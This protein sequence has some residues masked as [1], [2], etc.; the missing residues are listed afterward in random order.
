MVTVTVAVIIFAAGNFVFNIE[1]T[2]CM[3]APESTASSVTNIIGLA[4]FLSRLSIEIDSSNVIFRLLFLLF[5]RIRCSKTRIKSFRN[6]GII[7]NNGINIERIPLP[8]RDALVYTISDTPRYEDV[9]LAICSPPDLI[10]TITSGVCPVK[11][12]T[13][14]DISLHASR[15]LIFERVITFI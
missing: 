3:V 1:T 6:E 5:F 12:M 9:S 2:P 13:R 10:P 4:I 15:S 14:L 11:S 7:L 8:G